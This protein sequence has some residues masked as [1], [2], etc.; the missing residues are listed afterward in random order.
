[1]VILVIMDTQLEKLS[2]HLAHNIIEL[3]QI[4]NLTQNA[5]A[6]LVGVPRSTIANIESGHGNPS[7]AN[8][9]KISTALQTPI[10]ELLNP[11]KAICT[12]IKAEETP[13]QERAQ[14]LVKIFK[15]LPDKSTNTSIERMEIR[16]CGLMKGTPHLSG[17]KEYFHCIQ[18]EIIIRISSQDYV[19][20]KGGTLAFPGQLPHTYLN[21]GKILGIGFSVVVLAPLSI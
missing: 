9:S 18:G 19:V 11:K 3:R 13:M 6:K 21:E 17:T 8:L 10:D 12:L 14:G 2:T 1:M 20:K 15:L 4:R 7:L 16:P 5:L